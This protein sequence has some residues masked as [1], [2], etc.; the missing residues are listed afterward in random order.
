MYAVIHIIYIYIIYISY[1]LY[2]APNS[3]LCNQNTAEL[4]NVASTRSQQY[5]TLSPIIPQQ[6][7]MCFATVC[8]EKNDENI[9]GFKYNI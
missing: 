9:N 2:I 7:T 8:D 5:L 4:V 6:S 3:S 1:I